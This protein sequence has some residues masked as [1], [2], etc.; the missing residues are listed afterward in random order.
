MPG[1]VRNTVDRLDKPSAYYQ[2]K[3]IVLIFTGLC[4]RLGLTNLTILE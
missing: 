1:V 3:V 2:A 4:K